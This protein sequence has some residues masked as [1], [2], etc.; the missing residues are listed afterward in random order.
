LVTR[1][2]ST[3]KIMCPRKDW[4]FSRVCPWNIS[5]LTGSTGGT[6]YHPLWTPRNGIVGLT[7][8][9]LPSPNRPILQP[10]RPSGPRCRGVRT[11]PDSP[12]VASCWIWRNSRRRGDTGAFKPRSH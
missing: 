4:G 11:N 2:P 7:S 12:V 5:D 10:Q 8:V 1:P 9:L 3:R 6:L